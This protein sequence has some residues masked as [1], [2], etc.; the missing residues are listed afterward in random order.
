M[1]RA[2]ESPST[3]QR[4]TGQ[5]ARRAARNASITC[6]ATVSNLEKNDRL[7]LYSKLC[8]KLGGR[9][10]PFH[11]YFSGQESRYAQQTYTALSLPL[12]LLVFALVYSL[13]KTAAFCFTCKR[14]AKYI[15]MST[16]S[17]SA[18]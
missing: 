12:K 11:V 6:N 8:S 13:L 7:I 16:I 1:R 9:C 18:S 3:L 15:R 5:T 2:I 17:G 4:A 10:Y 14:L